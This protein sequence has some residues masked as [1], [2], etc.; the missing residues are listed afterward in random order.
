MEQKTEG[1]YVT[2]MTLYSMRSGTLSQWS[3]FRIWLASEDLGAATTARA[4][5]VSF[6]Y[7]GGDLIGFL[8]DNSIVNYSNQAWSEQK[9]CQ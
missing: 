6:E 5:Q 1:V 9:L 4:S 3:D 8:E 2:E 7:A